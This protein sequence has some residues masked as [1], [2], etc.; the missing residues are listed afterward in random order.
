MGEPLERPRVRREVHI[1]T[2]PEGVGSE[3]GLDL[4]G[5]GWAAVNTFRNFCPTISFSR[6]P[7]LHEVGCL[8]FAT[9]HSSR[10]SG[11]CHSASW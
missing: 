4:S 1:Q 5:E 2:G 10:M 7:L 9:L 3:C 6:R 11:F 8:S